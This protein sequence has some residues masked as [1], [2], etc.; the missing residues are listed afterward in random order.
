MT[1]L[2]FHAKPSFNILKVCRATQASK[3]GDRNMRPTAEVQGLLFKTCERL[4]PLSIAA[5]L[6]VAAAGPAPAAGGERLPAGARATPGAEVR[7]DAMPAPAGWITLF[8][9]EDW[10]KNL[11]SPER[12]FTGVL[13]AVPQR[14]D[15]M[16]TL[17]RTT[18]Y[19]LDKRAV[20]TGAKTVPA[21]DALVG[22]VVTFRGKPYEIELEGQAV[23]EIWPASVMETREPLHPTIPDNTRP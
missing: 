1:K 12:L 7:E 19:T 18:L 13:H 9:D 15:M 20:Y 22:K 21:L 10:Y 4:A 16:T 6:C 5:L 11:R 2:T 23:R 3:Q 8:A 17:Q 14:A